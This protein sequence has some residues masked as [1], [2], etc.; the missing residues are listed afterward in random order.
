[1][2]LYISATHTTVGGALVEESEVLKGDK[3]TLHQAPI[4][5]VSE[6]LAGSK[7]YYL[8][9]EKICYAVV[10]SARKLRH[11]FEAHRVRVLTNQPLNDIFENRDSSGRIGKW[12]ME[13]LE[14]VID[15]EKRSAIKSQ[16]MADFIVDWTEPSGYTEGTTVD[17]P[18]KVYCDR[19]WGVSGAGATAI[20]NSPSGI[21]LKYAA[22][23]QF[24]VEAD[25]CS[26]SIAEYEAVLLGLCKL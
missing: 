7:M 1:L 12:A 19:V 3:K 14:H 22:R 23:L 24:K 18:W 16:V 21:K 2:I 25:K 15:F 8:E 26:N 20:L 17:T 6:A 10:M 13:L 4:Y 5:F 11:Y 9:I